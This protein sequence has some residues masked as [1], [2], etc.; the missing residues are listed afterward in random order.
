MQ[1]A[2]AGE[3]AASVNIN[4]LARYVLAVQGGMALQARD[5]ASR[6]ELENVARYAMPRWGAWA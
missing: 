2:S 4:G 6:A 5:G 1:A 3:L